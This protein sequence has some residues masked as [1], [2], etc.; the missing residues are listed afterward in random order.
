MLITALAFMTGCT[1]D[2]CEQKITM[3][4]LPAVVK[5]AAEKELVGTK[6]CEVERELKKDGKVVYEISYKEN[7]KEMKL[8]YD[9]NGKLL[10]K[11]RD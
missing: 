1:T 6:V 5:F 10:R 9:Q 2:Q 4:Q 3:D 8:K 7:D 11:E